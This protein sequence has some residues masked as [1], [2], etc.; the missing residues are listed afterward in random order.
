MVRLTTGSFTPDI[1]PRTIGDA[2]VQVQIICMEGKCLS[3]SPDNYVLFSS[4]MCLFLKKEQDGE[5]SWKSSAQL[6]HFH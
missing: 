3:Y 5:A 2:R 4:R 1:V 6:Y